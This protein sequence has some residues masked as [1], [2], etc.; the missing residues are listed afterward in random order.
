M[1][2]S[3]YQK[4]AGRTLIDDSQVKPLGARQH[5]IVWN[6]VGLVGEAGEVLTY[7]PSP[8]PDCALRLVAVACGVAETVK[9]GIFHEQG[10]NTQWMQNYLQSV[11]EAAR[12]VAALSL[13]EGARVLTEKELGDV[14]W[15]V[16]ALCTCLEIDM[17]ELLPDAGSLAP[18]M[19]A[20]IAKLRLRFPE[21]WDA[22]AS[23]AKA[24]EALV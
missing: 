24:D 20:N 1:N 23:A 9:K 2:A 6:S 14:C 10:L 15:Y 11:L 22:A 5:R 3:E 4:Q 13:W 16:A 19:E 18:I 12:D 8:V 7:M 17:A 21:G